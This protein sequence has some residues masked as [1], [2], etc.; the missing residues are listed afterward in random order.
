MK[1][2]DSCGYILHEGYEDLHICPVKY[3]LLSPDSVN[4][5][6]LER[7]EIIILLLQRLVE[8]KEESK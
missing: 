4:V 5:L 6:V 7:L 2:C 3:K 1:T 8:K